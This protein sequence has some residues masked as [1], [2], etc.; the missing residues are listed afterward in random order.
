MTLR[1]RELEMHV[2]S[3]VLNYFVIRVYAVDNTIDN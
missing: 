3:T 1:R 2:N